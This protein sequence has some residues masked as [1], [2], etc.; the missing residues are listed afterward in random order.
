MLL[1]PVASGEYFRT[2]QL[3]LEESVP[4]LDLRRELLLPGNRPLWPK[5]PHQLGK[6]GAN[7]VRTRSDR[8][9]GRR[10]ARRAI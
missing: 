1:F 10:M 4:R 9:G 5:K 8:E 3:S 6:R 7:V 2:W